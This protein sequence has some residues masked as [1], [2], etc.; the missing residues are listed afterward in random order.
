MYVKLP[1]SS[2]GA[3]VVQAPAAIL[4][5]IFSLPPD[6]AFLFTFQVS[7][8]ALLFVGTAVTLGLEAKDLS[9]TPVGICMEKLA[10]KKG[11]LTLLKPWDDVLWSSRT[12]A[13]LE[14]TSMAE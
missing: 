7:R 2:S 14:L 10:L 8:P 13:L 6:L 9:T 12:V 1:R 4:R 5:A 11:D 3:G